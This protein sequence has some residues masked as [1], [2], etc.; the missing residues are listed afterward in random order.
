MLEDVKTILAG[1][2]TTLFQDAAGIA[3][4]GVMMTVMLY[5]PKLM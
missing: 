5:L 2:R 4:I 1:S 3:A